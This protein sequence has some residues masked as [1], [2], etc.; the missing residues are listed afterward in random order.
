MKQ[1]FV[2]IDGG[3]TK[4][5]AVVMDSDCR[6]VLQ[7]TGESTNPHAVT[8]PK[9]LQNLGNLLDAIR[10]NPGTS[11]WQSMAIGL[12][13]V[14]TG[15]EQATVHRY[16]EQYKQEHGLN[17]HCSLLNDAQIALMATLQ[18]EEGIIA[19]SGT[20][21]IIYGLT[22]TAEQ[23]RTGGWGHLLGDEGSGYDIGIRALKAVMRS[24][25]GIAPPT[26]MTS[27]IVDSYGF[28]SI[29]ELKPFIYGD[30]IHK[31][32][33][34]KFAEIVI[35]ASGQNDSAA[36]TI[37]QQAAGEMANAAI[38]L[39]GKNDWFKSCDLVMTG[40]IFAHS[41][42]FNQTFRNAIRAAFAEIK[43]HTASHTPAYGA[44]LL[45]LKHNIE[46]LIVKESD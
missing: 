4:T 38:T 27:L 35:R 14:S 33:I 26:L 39:I 18:R 15:A 46:P 1:L 23:Y 10:F 16:L 24:Y 19:I 29:T 44:A 32:D 13:G 45:A 30:A 28:T 43:F 7:L 21:S 31:S 36:I 41:E 3:G 40:S 37:I 2:G 11:E 20:G 42:L 8:F 34:A 25:D 9:A 12:S 22:P 5:E 6:I 17:F